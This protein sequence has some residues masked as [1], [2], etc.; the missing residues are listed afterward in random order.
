MYLVKSPNPRYLRHLSQASS[1]AWCCWCC[2]TCRKRKW[3]WICFEAS[4]FHHC[5]SSVISVPEIWQLFCVLRCEHAFFN[6]LGY[7]VDHRI[8]I[9]TSTGFK[10]RAQI[11]FLTLSRLQE[12][13]NQLKSKR[14]TT[15]RCCSPW[16]RSRHRLLKES[17]PLLLSRLD[18]TLDLVVL[19]LVL[20]EDCCQIW[21]EKHNFHQGFISVLLPTGQ[22]VWI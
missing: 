19:V 18:Q 2:P 16:R 14:L 4:P 15:S 7:L 17:R 21:A 5:Q 20:L 12:I 22:S 8:Y 3:F 10:E 11:W 6:V 9:F 13:L 1:P